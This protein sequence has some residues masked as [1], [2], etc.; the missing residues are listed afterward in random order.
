MEK[1]VDA[2]LL[3]GWVGADKTGGTL[4]LRG[5]IGVDKAGGALL[6]PCRDG[7]RQQ[8][9]KMECGCADWGISGF[10]LGV[11]TRL[12]SRIFSLPAPYVSKAAPKFSVADRKSV[13]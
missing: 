13:V 2:L 10:G 9:R 4:V 8:V 6:C 5:W 7:V 11:F 3:R 1:A 12:K